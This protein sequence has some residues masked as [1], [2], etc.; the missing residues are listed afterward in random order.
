MRTKTISITDEAYSILKAKKYNTESFSEL[1]I[2]LSGKKS[3]ACFY[4]VLS[5]KSADKLEESINNIR[6]KRL[7]KLKT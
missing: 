2:R 4:G 3:L 6:K 1:I 7:T 5:K